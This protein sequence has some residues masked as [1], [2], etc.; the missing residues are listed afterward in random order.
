[1]AAIGPEPIDRSETR[2]AAESGHADQQAATRDEVT[3]RL[4]VA[5]GLAPS[6]V[7]PFGLVFDTPLN[8]CSSR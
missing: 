1:M 3:R 4:R 7:D 2:G 5:V 8:E 6:L